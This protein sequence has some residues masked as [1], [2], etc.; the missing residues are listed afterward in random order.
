MDQLN[1]LYC[2]QSHL[3]ERFAEII[4]Q[5]EVS[6]LAPILAVTISDMEI[7]LTRTNQY[8]LSTCTQYSFDQCDNML[9]SL[10]DDFELLQDHLADKPLRDKFLLSYLQ[11]IQNIISAA[12]QLLR[13][14]K[15]SHDSHLAK[16]LGSSDEAL[17]SGE[18]LK[19][20]LIT[21]LGMD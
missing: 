11:N 3:C 17:S 10:E 8:F 13:L 16:L 2:A 14:K 19:L 21:R 7:Q 5:T 1:K 20:D 9:K 12:I 6:D 4:D 15:N 18:A